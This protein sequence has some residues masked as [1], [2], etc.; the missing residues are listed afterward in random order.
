[1][2]F[3]RFL[4]LSSKQKSPTVAFGLPKHSQLS[5]LDRVEHFHHCNLPLVAVVD[6][7]LIA[8]GNLPIHFSWSS[9]SHTTLGGGDVQKSI[10]QIVQEL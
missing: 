2:S 8:I 10:E 5:D 1:M 9:K 7:N 4:P 3:D 6:S